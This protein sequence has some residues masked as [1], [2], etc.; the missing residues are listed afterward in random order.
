M[1]GLEIVVCGLGSLRVGRV[2]GG[3]GPYES[4]GNK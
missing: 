2:A 4:V 3:F 1:G